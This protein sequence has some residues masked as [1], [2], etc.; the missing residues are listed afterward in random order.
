[1]EY[2]SQC[3]MVESTT[4]GS[5]DEGLVSAKKSE[6]TLK[7]RIKLNNCCCIPS[8]KENGSVVANSSKWFLTFD[9][10][11]FIQELAPDRCLAAFFSDDELQL[12]QSTHLLSPLRVF[13][14]LLKSSRRV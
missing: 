5:Y 1:M 8:V 9:Q 6:S 13:L 14:P 2:Q 4:W 7:L 12:A 10:L 11:F 3:E